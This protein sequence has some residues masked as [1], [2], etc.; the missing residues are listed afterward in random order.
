MFD[1]WATSLFGNNQSTKGQP[2]YFS[3]FLSLYI[4]SIVVMF[5]SVPQYQLSNENPDLTVPCDNA[6][7]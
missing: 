7:F 3:L 4:F 1:S 5:H 6:I 2:V